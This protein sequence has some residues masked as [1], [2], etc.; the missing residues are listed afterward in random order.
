VVD[1][2]ISH[3]EG[4]MLRFQKKLAALI[5]TIQEQAALDEKAYVR[6]MG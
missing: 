1:L 6:K 5:S 2:K 3:P 4:N